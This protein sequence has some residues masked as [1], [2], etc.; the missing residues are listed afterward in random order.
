MT[1][2]HK[3]CTHLLVLL[4]EI[5]TGWKAGLAWV[6]AIPVWLDLAIQIIADVVLQACVLKMPL[7]EHV[8]SLCESS[9]TSNG[10]VP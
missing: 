2:Q 6:Q 3:E 4:C 5:E 10:D 8:P 7:H 9:Q 1:S